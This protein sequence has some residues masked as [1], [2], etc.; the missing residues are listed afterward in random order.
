V[1]PDR[2]LDQEVRKFTRERRGGSS[3]DDRLGH[4]AIMAARGRSGKVPRPAGK[5]PA[6]A[7]T[8]R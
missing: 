8:D 5:L 1:Q 6:L 2:Q 7:C 3:A 4:D